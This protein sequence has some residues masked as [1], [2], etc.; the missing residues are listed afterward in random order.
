MRHALMTVSVLLIGALGTPAAAAEL[1]RCGSTCPHGD[2]C[3]LEVGHELGH[4]HACECN[5]PN[6]ERGA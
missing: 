4:N 1:L 6:T 2:R 5:E 3:R